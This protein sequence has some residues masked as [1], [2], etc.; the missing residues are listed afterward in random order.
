MADHAELRNR[1]A[2]G[3]TVFGVGDRN[4]KDVFG[5]ANGKPAE[6]QTPDIEDVESDDMP[7]AGLAK[8]I[9]DRHRDVVDDDRRGGTALDPHLI[10]VSA[11]REPRE[12]ALDQKCGE[13]F[14]VDFGEYREDAGLAAVGDPHLLAVENVMR[15]I[16]RQ[17]G[18]SF[19]RKRVRSGLRFAEA[20]RGNHFAAGNPGQV[21]LLLRLRSEE[22]KRES[23]DARMSAMPAA[24]GAIARELLGDH[25]HGSEI[26]FHAA[27]AFRCENGFQP[28]GRG[29]AQ[30]RNGD[31]EV[32]VLH[33]L[34][35]RPHFVVEE[36]ACGA[37]NVVMLL[38]EVFRSK[39]VVRR[40]ILY[41]KGPAGGF[42]GDCGCH[43]LTSFRLYNLSK[44][45]AAPCPPPTHIVTKP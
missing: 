6:L 40:L 8:Q 42:R 33:C 23:P 7:A 14:A 28:Q 26:H 19:G 25:H 13:L 27:V 30:Q 35:V 10:F 38:G 9:L 17:I 1:G 39:D 44:T 5:A 2:E 32:A 16:G 34:D 24:E 18:A 36:L 21:F 12:R 11:I 31:V 20:V 41:K 3:F 43:Q 4:L 22:Q 29:F 15:A 45:P 37:G